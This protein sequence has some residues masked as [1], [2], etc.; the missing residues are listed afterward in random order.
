MRRSRTYLVEYRAGRGRGFPTR[1]ISIGRHGALTP[2]QARQL[3]KNPLPELPRGKIRPRPGQSGRRSRRQRTLSTALREHGSRSGSLVPPKRSRRSSTGRHSDFGSIRLSGAD[4]SQIRAW[5]SK[6]T[7]RPRQATFDLAILRKALNIAV[8]DDLLTD[9]PARG[10]PP[11]PEKERDRVPTDQE[12]RR[13]GMRL[14]R[15]RSGRALGFSSSSS[16]LRD[17]VVASGC[18]PSGGT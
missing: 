13:C 10:I 11:H 1:R 17:V 14:M 12:F 18:R 16:P 6:Q 4:P 3:A 8:G 2:E 9:N 5:H 15:R 7:H